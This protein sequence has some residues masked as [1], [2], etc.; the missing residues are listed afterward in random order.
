LDR[1]VRQIYAVDVG[2]GQLL[3]ALADDPRV[4]V[5]DRTNIRHLESLDGPVP[6][7]VTADLSF[8]SLRT[9]LPN[10]AKLASGAEM[11]ALFKP[12]F[13]VG[14]AHVR[15]GGIVR[16]A[17]VAQETIAGFLDW[18]ASAGLAESLHPPEA[19]ALKGAKGNQEWLLHLRLGSADA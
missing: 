15:S 17:D 9:V 1:G 18:A 10:I 14:R 2:H 8:I 12:Q 7:M 5:M 13:E 3:P 4:I 11:V 19:S 16:D 6:D